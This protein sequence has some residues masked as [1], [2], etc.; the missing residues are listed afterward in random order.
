MPPSIGSGRGGLPLATWETTGSSNSPGRTSSG[1]FAD[2]QGKL[3]QW[4]FFEFATKVSDNPGYDSLDDSAAP[5]SAA[6]ASA[7]AQPA[8]AGPP[9]ATVAAASP[10]GVALS[11]RPTTTALT[12]PIGPAAA[13][14]ASPGQTLSLR[15]SGVTTDRPLGV[16][17]NVYLNLENPDRPDESRRVGTISFFG[18]GGHGAH[19]RGPGPSPGRTFIFPLD[20][21][22]R[23]MAEQGSELRLTFVPSA[24]FTGSPVRVGR[25]E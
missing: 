14:A 10:A 23:A 24:P 6:A 8:G 9:Q 3:V 2:E 22:L 1:S 7:Q 16:V 25:I 13:A 4:T 19:G 20:G 12:L 18:A 21:P 5:S 11:G 17:Y 15:L